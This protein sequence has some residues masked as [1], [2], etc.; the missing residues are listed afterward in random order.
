LY[1][2]LHGLH[3]RKLQCMAELRRGESR[4]EDLH[5]LPRER[6]N[7]IVLKRAAEFKRKEAQ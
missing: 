6:V 1:D 7:R 5:R 3:G 2:Y 4:H